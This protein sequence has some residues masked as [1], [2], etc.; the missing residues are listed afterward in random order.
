[1]AH[2]PDAVVIIATSLSGQ[3]WL[4]D[5]AL[6]HGAKAVLG[7]PVKPYELR[8][9]LGQHLDNLDSGKTKQDSEDMQIESDWSQLL[10]VNPKLLE[11]FCREA[12]NAIVTLREAVGSSDIGGFTTTTHAM[13]SALANIGENEKSEMAYALEQAGNNGDL[14]FITANIDKFVESLEVLVGSLSSQDSTNDGG[15]DVIEDA[16]YLKSQLSMIKAACLD[17]DDSLAYT[18]LSQLE[19]R[20]WKK[21]T[22]VILANIRDMLY[23]SSDF[24]GAVAQ[25]EVLLGR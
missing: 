4:I 11:V 22:A 7:K 10:V 25:V 6:S 19:E 1:M 23:L 5:E 20:V 16:D 13:K 14:A 9:I 15:D 17:Y 8:K 21:E 2:D 12:E 18:A 24:E 3:D